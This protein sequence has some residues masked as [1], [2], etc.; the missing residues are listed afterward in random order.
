MADI[1]GCARA[2][3]RANTAIA[4]PLQHYAAGCRFEWQ[5]VVMPQVSFPTFQRPNIS[6]QDLSEGQAGPL[7]FW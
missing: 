7:A 6:N 4:E 3:G 2:P 5:D 1:A